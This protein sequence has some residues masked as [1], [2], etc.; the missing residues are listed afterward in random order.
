M[1]G[2]T[3]IGWML[4]ALLLGAGMGAKSA[5][6]SQLRID[7]ESEVKRLRDQ[8]LAGKAKLPA[9]ELER[10]GDLLSEALDKKQ[11]AV[12]TVLVQRSRQ[13]DA[14]YQTAL[15]ALVRHKKYGPPDLPALCGVMAAELPEANA[16]RGDR[17]RID[18]V[19]FRLRMADWIAEL[20]GI[21]PLPPTADAV[22][23]QNAIS[24]PRQWVRDAVRRAE[25]SGRD[26]TAAKWREQ[27]ARQAR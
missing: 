10:L 17:S 24:D 20:L 1:A 3:A 8:G 21:A 16:G 19:T 23:K 5:D 14:V 27:C 13:D 2:R 6:V 11:A 22:S 4:S 18:P 25:K 9:G 12:V 7:I 26:K 15:W